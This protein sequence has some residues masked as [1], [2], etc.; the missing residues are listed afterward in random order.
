MRNLNTKQLSTMP[1]S[2]QQLEFKSQKSDSKLVLSTI[3]QEYAF[4][5]ALLWD[6]KKGHI[7]ECQ[8]TKYFF[9][10]VWQVQFFKIYNNA[11]TLKE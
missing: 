9:F 8:Y 6:V 10:H 3:S 11:S 1:K 4:F 5:L 7:S 2:Q